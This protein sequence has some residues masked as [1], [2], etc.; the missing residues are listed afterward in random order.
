MFFCQDEISEIA[1]HSLV[2]IMQSPYACMELI[3]RGSLMTCGFDSYPVYRLTLSVVAVHSKAR[4]PFLLATSYFTLNHH[5][6]HVLLYL[7]SMAVQ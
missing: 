5:F 1:K 2:D 6:L 3:H 4:G 7:G